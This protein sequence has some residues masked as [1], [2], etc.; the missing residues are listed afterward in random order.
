MHQRLF[1]ERQQRDEALV[2]VCGCHLG[3]GAL[4]DEL[5]S[6]FCRQGRQLRHE[7]Q[8]ADIYIARLIYSGSRFCFCSVKKAE[9]PVEGADRSTNRKGEGDV[10][11]AFLVFSFAEQSECEG[12]ETCR[13]RVV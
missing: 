8:G 11:G 3:F 7:I 2:D 10:V 5:H 9:L 1:G 13:H 4:F 6:F 12:E